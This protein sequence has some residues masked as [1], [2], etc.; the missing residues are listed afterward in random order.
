MTV[1]Y[2]HNFAGLFRFRIIVWADA[3]HLLWVSC[4]VF[5]GPIS[6]LTFYNYDKAA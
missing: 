1:Y 2:G 4:D 6:F 3:E 5:A